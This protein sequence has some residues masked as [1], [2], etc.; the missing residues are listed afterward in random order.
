VDV[1]GG[2]ALAI[3]AV[4]LGDAIYDRWTKRLKIED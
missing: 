2:T 4:P 1:I 3:V